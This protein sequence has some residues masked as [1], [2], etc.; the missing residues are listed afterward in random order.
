MRET[1]EPC[2]LEMRTQL[3]KKGLTV[4]IAYQSKNQALLSKNCL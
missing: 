4:E 1:W 3:S 2:D